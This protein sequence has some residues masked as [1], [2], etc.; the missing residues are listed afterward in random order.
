M[1]LAAAA[2]VSG[3]MMSENSPDLIGWLSSACAVASLNACASA[4]AAACAAGLPGPPFGDAQEQIAT[5]N[6]AGR[7]SCEIRDG[8]MALLKFVMPFIITAQVNLGVCYLLL[9]FFLAVI[10][11]EATSLDKCSC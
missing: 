2:S 1:A 9:E 6:V 4:R 3:V 10:G 8:F 7:I 11:E 5:A